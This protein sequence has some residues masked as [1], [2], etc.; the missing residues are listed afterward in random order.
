[1]D[2]GLFL[3]STLFEVERANASRFRRSKWSR[4]W[5]SEWTSVMLPYR[6]AVEQRFDVSIRLIYRVEDSISYFTLSFTG[7]DSLWREPG[8]LIPPSMITW[9]TWTPCGPN[10]RAIDCAKAR[11][12]NFDAAK[13]PNLAEPRR[14]AVAP[15]NNIVPLPFFTIDGKTYRTHLTSTRSVLLLFYFL[16]GNKRADD[17][18][19]QRF[20]KCFG[21]QIQNTT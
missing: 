2:E 10:S 7:W 4:L 1:M 3:V 18:D 15:V 5:F 14:L 11:K 19:V 16:T 20:L 17:T 21:F 12:A 13:P 9:A 6:I 8:V